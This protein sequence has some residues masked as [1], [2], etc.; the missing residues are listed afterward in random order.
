MNPKTT[1]TTLPDSKPTLLLV[2]DD[3]LILAIIA[4]GLMGAGYQVSKAE[5]ADEAENLL[6]A[7]EKPD[8]IL[9]DVNMPGRSGLD[10][11]V[12]LNKL[13][14]IPFILLTAYNDN[15]IVEQAAANGAM[16]YLV[17]PVE[18]S[19]IIPAIET[20]LLRAKDIK[21]LRETGNQLQTALSAERDISIAVG[22]TMAQY[23]VDRK[24]AFDKLRKT[25][26]SQRRRLAELAHE[27]INA[28]E[29]INLAA[30]QK[31]NDSY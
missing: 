24:T 9:L 8:L 10:L 6:R 26:R 4:K 7:G 17:K 22:I 27:I 12:L 30:N 11:A 5:S 19:Q 29:V 25:A 20:A 14:F 23:H 31:K 15:A 28:C 13:Y 2:D 21:E 1:I 18:V 3:R 16:G